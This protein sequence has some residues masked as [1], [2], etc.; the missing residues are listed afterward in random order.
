MIDQLTNDHYE[1]LKKCDLH[2]CYIGCNLF[3]ELTKQ[4]KPLELS[5]DSTDIVQSLIVGELTVTEDQSLTSV[6]T[7]DLNEGL[8][9]KDPQTGAECLKTDKKA[10]TK[11]RTPALIEQVQSPDPTLK[12]WETPQKYIKIIL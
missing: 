8:A 7:A 11:S 2:L 4:E 3:I 9:R 12:E 10:E 5:H 1:D 6:L